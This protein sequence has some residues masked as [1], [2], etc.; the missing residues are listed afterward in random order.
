MGYF[1]AVAPGTRT[2]ARG[3]SSTPSYPEKARSPC[4]LEPITIRPSLMA[5]RDGWKRRHC[6]VFASLALPCLAYQTLGLSPFL[7]ADPLPG[8]DRS[9]ATQKSYLTL[10]LLFAASLH[11]RRPCYDRCPR[12]LFLSR[13]QRCHSLS[14]SL[15][16]FFNRSR[17]SK[18]SPSIA[19]LNLLCHY[20]IFLCHRQLL[21]QRDS[22][23]SCHS[24]IVPM[25]SSSVVGLNSISSPLYCPTTAYALSF[26]LCI[27]RVGPPFPAMLVPSFSAKLT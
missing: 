24:S 9:A 3:I 12:F 27:P 2:L 13:D 8:Y 11:A 6:F 10:G 15:S 26:L 17:N 20:R 16:P 5:G 18:G 21:A 19:T 22:S 25:P 1:R 23:I 7:S 4:V 14:Q